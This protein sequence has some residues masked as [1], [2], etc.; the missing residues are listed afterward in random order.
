MAI[1][2]FK[3]INFGTNQKAVYDFL[4]L[5]N[6]NYYRIS[7]HFQVIADCW[8]AWRLFCPSRSFTVTKFGTNQKLVVDFI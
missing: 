3:V 8:Y 7:H 6:I 1:S 2:P 5:S 4:L